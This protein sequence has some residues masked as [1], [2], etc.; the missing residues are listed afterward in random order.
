MLGKISNRGLSRLLLAAGALAAFAAV[1]PAVADVKVEVA[2]TPYELRGLTAKAIDEDI[3]RSA[4][5]EGEGIV[6]GEVNDEVSWALDFAESNGTCSVT[7]DNILLKLSVMMPVWVD[8]DRAPQNVRDSWNTYYRDLKTHEDGHK[9]IAMDAVNQ[10]SK[11]THGATA[12]GPCSAMKASLEK[13]ARD[14]VEASEQAQ[15]RHDA[16]DTKQFELQ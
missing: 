4:K 2:N 13:S 11:L 7:S 3:H 12:P 15:E 14:I 9:T 8:E 5:K 16:A 6:E 1:S 10:I